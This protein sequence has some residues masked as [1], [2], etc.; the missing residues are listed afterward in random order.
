MADRSKKRLIERARA[1]C[2]SSGYAFT[3]VSVKL[4]GGG[5][6]LGKIEA[7]KRDIMV[8]TLDRAFDRLDQLEAD[9]KAREQL[10][11]KPDA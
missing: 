6:D 1:Y 11:E 9:Q 7:G 8:A 5:A 3:T 4:L 2:E 10:K